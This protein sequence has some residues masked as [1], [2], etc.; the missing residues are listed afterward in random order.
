M[1]K[2]LIVEQMPMI[3]AELPEIN[4]LHHQTPVCAL[5][6]PV[7]E[8]T[9]ITTVAQANEAH[10]RI[11]RLFLDAIGLGKFLLEEK[12]KVGHSNW[13]QWV[14][15]K[16]EFTSRTAARYMLLYNQR[17]QLAT[18]QIGHALSDLS[19]TKA[20]KILASNKKRQQAKT[21]TKKETTTIVSTE[22]TNHSNRPYLPD[23]YRSP[24]SY[25]Q[26]QRLS[27]F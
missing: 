15:D 19:M 3:S 9:E 20:L 4:R 16:L 13:E 17:N 5:F 23:A 24:S 25:K 2:P 8:G 14:R 22:Q 7:I 27:L 18:A 12:E 26:F 11:N 21:A 6:G 1:R 10:H